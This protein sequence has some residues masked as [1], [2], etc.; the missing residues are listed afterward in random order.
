M[1]G[2]QNKLAIDMLNKAAAKGDWLCLKNIHLV[3]NWLPELEK[4]LRSL[5]L[6]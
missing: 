6:H 1:G 4:N 2:N 3:I 5:I